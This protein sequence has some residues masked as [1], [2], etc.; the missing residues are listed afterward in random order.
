MAAAAAERSANIKKDLHEGSK[1]L[2]VQGTIDKTVD[3]DEK[4][5][6]AYVIECVQQIATNF[7]ETEDR[8]TGAEVVEF[9]MRFPMLFTLKEDIGATQ[10]VEQK[11]LKW[12]LAAAVKF[13]A[14]VIPAMETGMQASLA[15]TMMAQ[16]GKLHLSKEERSNR[17]EGLAFYRT[18]GDLSSSV[19]MYH[20]RMEQTVEKL[21]GLCNTVMKEKQTITYR[22]TELEVNNQLACELYGP[23]KNLEISEIRSLLIPLISYAHR[24]QVTSFRKFVDPDG[25]RVNWES[26]KD[27]SAPH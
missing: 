17:F 25:N 5:K 3:T 21:Q 13:V 24:Q 1:A 9:M 26:G 8:L 14:A 22:H 15:A 16:F 18:Y 19:H 12:N 11:D 10:T 6:I 7:L 2:H 20:V 27:Q 4:K 23:L